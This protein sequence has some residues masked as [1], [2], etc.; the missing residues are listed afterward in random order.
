M[1]TT[2]TKISVP[3]EAIVRIGPVM[4]LPALLSELG[5]DPESILV[6]YG[7]K[8]W[9]F[10]NPDN[11]I[12]YVR[13]SH[14]L[15]HCVDITGCEE[16]GLLLGMR[17]D[18]SCL[19]IAGFMLQTA[20]DVETALYALVRH[21]S[22]HDEGGAPSLKISGDFSYLGFAIN[23]PE[24]RAKD[25]IYDESMAVA[26]NIMRGLC[27]D[28]WNPTEV[29]LSRPPPKKLSSYKAF[30]KAPMRFDAEQ[31]AV[32]FPTRFL[33]R[34]LQSHIP[35]LHDYLETKATELHDER[36]TDLIGRLHRFM[37]SALITKECS[38]STA[39][40][41][42]GIHKR[43]LNRLL[44]K[45]GSS[46]RQELSKLRYAMARAFLANSPAKQAEIALA[47]GYADAT[48]FSRAFK[49]W[50]DMTPE[51]WR[52]RNNIL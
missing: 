1:E 29:L 14:L 45:E 15:E 12:P 28:D 23:L 38:S 26:C 40:Q 27:G 3:G 18:P 37:R 44:R 30:F 8:P 51:E 21:F 16:L 5:H 47:L 13:G 46:F 52:A 2:A 42:L 32:V 49:R 24:A 25:Q 17:A 9:Q 4:N 39:A 19:G 20:P 36:D 34:K 6:T 11:E 7:F 31:S 10:N 48:T 50:S 33:R 43:T 22:L 41:Y 35:L